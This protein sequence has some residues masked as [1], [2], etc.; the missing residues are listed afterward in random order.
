M[1]VLVA[2]EKLITSTFFDFDG[3]RLLTLFSIESPMTITSFD[4]QSLLEF[5]LEAS[6]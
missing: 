3:P 2:Q 1:S 6:S 5:S 4:L